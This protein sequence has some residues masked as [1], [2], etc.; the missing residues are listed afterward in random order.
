[1]SSDACKASYLTVNPAPPRD[2]TLQTRLEESPRTRQ[3]D[4]RH[5]PGESHPQAVS[6]PPELDESEVVA[7]RP[8][9]PGDNKQFSHSAR[10]SLTDSPRTARSFP[11]R[12]A[13]HSH[14]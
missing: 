10:L 13:S 12:S 14:P 7:V 6:G 9:P 2:D 11:R 1:M 3:T 8:I 5:A 4:R